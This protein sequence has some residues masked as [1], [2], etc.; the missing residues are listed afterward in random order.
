[1]IWFAVFLIFILLAISACFAG[2]ETAVTAASPGKMQ[3]LKA[4]GNRRVMAALRL[5]K[6]KEKVISTLLVGNSFLNTVVTT[7]ATSM[8]ITL[9]GEEKGTILAGAV[10][11]VMIIVFAEVIPKAIA[12]T[13]AESILLMSA[14]AV[15]VALFMLRPVNFFLSIALRVFCF[16][17]RIKLTQTVSAT[18]EVRGVIDHHH[19]EGNVFKAD[20]D[21]LASVLDMRE[22]TVSEIMVH[23]SHIVSIDASLSIEEI[24]KRALGMPHTRIPLWRD[25]KEN[26]TSILHI[27]D[28]IRSLSK[29]K[30]DYSNVKLKDFTTDAWFIPDNAL[31]THQ[32]HAFR[33][34][35]SHVALVIDEYGDLQGLV[36]LE[37]ILEEI[38]GQIDDEHDVISSKIITKPDGRIIIDGSISVRDLNRELEWTLPDENAS[39]L[40][41]LIIHQAHKLPEQGEVFEMFDMKITIRKRLSNRIKTVVIEAL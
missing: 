14:K 13:K 40:A 11:T 29:N 22:M 41:G 30:F 36:T 37:D 6:M 26:I 32:L 5:L 4:E 1:M 25:S 39:T 9:F 34:K 38:V 24:A 15:N 28:L 35:R 33:Q 2:I 31:V 10:M 20:R 16:V 12:V 18:E 27:K 19:E 8:F 3:K 23:R 17:C 7:I 21:M